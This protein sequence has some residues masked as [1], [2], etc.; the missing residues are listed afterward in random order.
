MEPSHLQGVFTDVLC[1]RCCDTGRIFLWC[2]DVVK[3]LD[4]RRPSPK[5]PH[6]SWLHAS[7]LAL[8]WKLQS[9]KI[10]LSLANW[11]GWS[12]HLGHSPICHLPVM[13]PCRHEATSPG[14][15]HCPCVNWISLKSW[16][17]DLLPTQLLRSC[18]SFK[19]WLLSEVWWS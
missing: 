2:W 7:L 17:Q 19:A 6:V 5:L 11:D 13:N 16:L 12:S 1:H 18:T 10:P 15:L 8:H 4:I 9:W 3:Q 14:L